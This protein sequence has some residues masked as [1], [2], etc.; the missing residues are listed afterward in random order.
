M[1]P[2]MKKI[3]ICSLLLILSSSVFGASLSDLDEDS[4]TGILEFLSPNDLQSVR[5]TDKQFRD[6][7][8]SNSYLRNHM[9]DVTLADGSS[10]TLREYLAGERSQVLY[11]KNLSTLMNESHSSFISLMMKS[12]P[13]KPETVDSDLRAFHQ[14]T[15]Q[16]NN[17]IGSLPSYETS[18]QRLASV[19]IEQLTW[20]QVWNKL[21]GPILAQFEGQVIDQVIDQV[22]TQ[23]MTQVGAEAWSE[24]WAQLMDQV[25]DQVWAEVWALR[26]DQLWDQVWDQVEAQVND[27]L[28]HFDFA[29]A[30]DNE[31]LKGVLKPA[32]DYTFMIYQ[33]GTLAIGQTE[34]FKRTHLQLSQSISEIVTEEQANA[35]LKSIDIPDAPEGNYLVEAQLKLIKRHLPVAE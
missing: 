11:I 15:F 16:I 23:L 24:V 10:K 28:R 19:V 25:G 6:M 27:G 2:S 5:R 22:I 9:F 34:I 4:K 1:G 33:L 18:Q 35:I 13:N 32:I 30:F 29:L 12:I 8:A 17:L 26:M 21:L 31:N 20:D 7:L 14:N 3:L